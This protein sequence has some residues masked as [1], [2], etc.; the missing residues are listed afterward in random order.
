M[1]MWI[2]VV[3]MAVGLA[4]ASAA[5]DYGRVQ[6]GKTQ[7]RMAADAAARAAATRVGYS[8]TGVQDLAYDIANAN[9]C[10]GTAIAID[11]TTDVEFLD[12]NTTNRTFNVLSGTARIN[13]NAIRVTCKRTGANGIPLT[14]AWMGG[15]YRCN[16]TGVAIAC[17]TPPEFGM[18][19]LD[20]I[21]MNGNSAASY[22]SSTGVFAG[23]SGNIASNGNI[24]SSSPAN[25]KGY[26]WAQAGAT[27]TN[28][29]AFARRTLPGPLSY[30]NGSAEPYDLTTNDNNLLPGGLLN[31]SSKNLNTGNNPYNIPAGNYVVNGFALGANGRL[32]LQGPVTFY[33]Y[34]SV[35]LAGNAVTNGNIPKNLKLVMIP[36]PTSG[37][38]PGSVTISSGSGVYADIYAPQSAITLSGNGAIYGTVIGK[39]INMTGSSDI[40]YDLSVTTGG[41]VSIVK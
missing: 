12:W 26:V 1:A 32:N 25:I 3:F 7:L 8:I 36:H 15:H 6:L 21:N 17:V 23:N 16:A 5:V 11:K 34:G 2:V 33:V 24:I 27:V 20:F 38:A 40:Y 39:S 29:S 28:I 19:G 37:A 41:S 9:M 18:V 35:T 31:P 22:W 4:M 13:A 30:P 14:F 10:D